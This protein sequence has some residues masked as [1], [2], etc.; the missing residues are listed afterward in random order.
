M[1]FRRGLRVVFGQASLRI[2]LAVKVT[3]G[4]VPA[5]ELSGEL[6][7]ADEIRSF[8]QDDIVHLDAEQRAEILRQLVALGR[9]DH[10]C[11]S[12]RS[13]ESVLVKRLNPCFGDTHSKLVGQLVGLN[14]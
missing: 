9:C 5:L 14:T 10:R 4:N 12:V 13:L 3:V 2:Y 6:F 8:H 1:M 11:A 7:D